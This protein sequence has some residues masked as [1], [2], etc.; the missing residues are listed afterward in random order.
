MFVKSLIAASAVAVSALAFAPAEAT[1]KT[2]WNVNIGIGVPA[3]PV[4]EAPAYVY[5]P[6][7][8]V[9]QERP[10]YRYVAPVYGYGYVAPRY[11]YAERSYCNEGAQ[12][13]RDA[14]FR[15]VDAYDCSG[16][17][18]GYTGYRHGDLFKVR[19]NTAGDIVSVR[20]VD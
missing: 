18:Y 7:Y 14:G 17:I 15:G 9:Y 10:H 16:T 4:Y 12:T 8:P 11:R 6:A 1:A 3:Y 20:Q 2:H 13:V 5:E 19:V